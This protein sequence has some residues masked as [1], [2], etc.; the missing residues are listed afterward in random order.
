MAQVERGDIVE[1]E[2]PFPKVPRPSAGFA[3]DKPTGSGSAAPRAS[4][5]IRRSRSTLN[6][7]AARPGRLAFARA[8]CCAPLRTARGRWVDLNSA[9]GTRLKRRRQ[10]PAAPGEDRGAG[11]GPANRIPRGACGPT[12]TLEES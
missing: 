2:F 4:R 10:D 7:P 1:D 5:G 6:R 9:N 12:L 3:L 11:Q 8:S